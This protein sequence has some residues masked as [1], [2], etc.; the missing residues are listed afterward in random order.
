MNEVTT[1]QI[2]IHQVFRSFFRINSENAYFPQQWLI[3][4]NNGTIRKCMPL[5]RFPMN[6]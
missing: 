1:P 5:K 4:K 3:Q 6:G 2:G